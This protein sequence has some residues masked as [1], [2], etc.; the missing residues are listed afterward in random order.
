MDNT[1]KPK[2][3]SKKEFDA[4]TPAQ[5]TARTKEAMMQNLNLSD[6]EKKSKVKKDE[7][8]KDV[9]KMKSG[10]MAR[11]RI[12]E[13]NVPE[14]GPTKPMTGGP[15]GGGRKNPRLY[16]DPDLGQ[17]RPLAGE[18]PMT[19]GPFQKIKK[20]APTPSGGPKKRVTGGTS[21]VRKAK[22]PMKRVREDLS[23]NKRFKSGGKVR[24]CGMARGGSVR[25]CKMVKMKGA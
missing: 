23:P 6:N 13:A 25:P 12:T 10:G 5:K 7:K 18:T 22:A 17:P 19:G 8:M 20:P 9:K 11:K 4:M 24:G 16:S 21:P 3:P 2:V 15:Q 14:S 1:K